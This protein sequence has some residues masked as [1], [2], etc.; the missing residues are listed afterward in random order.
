MTSV[1]QRG[2]YGRYLHLMMLVADFGVLNIA[3]LLTC[4]ISPEF[5]ETRGRTVWLLANLTYIPITYWLNVTHKK[6]AIQMDHVVRNALR[7]VL[8]YALI[9]V[10]SVYF[11]GIDH[12]RWYVFVE[13][14]GL[15]LVIFPIW[16]SLS[17]LIL[18]E[19]RRHGKNFV[20]VVVIGA[21]PTAERLYREMLSD[22]GFGYKI[23]G[24]FDNDKATGDIPADLYM[25]G[26][27]NVAEFVKTQ[28]VDEMYFSIS[29]SDD[30]A[31]SMMIKVA[32]D[33]AIQFYY[34]PQISKYIKRE[35]TLE[36]MGRMP[37]M[38]TRYNPLGLM[39][40]RMAK[41]SFDVIFSSVALIC[42][43][44]IFIPVAIAIKLSSPGPVFFTQKRTG[45]RGREF[46]CYKFRTMRVNSQS[47]SAQA[48]AHD[49]RKTAVGD[50]LRRSSIDELP[51]FINVWL[52][53][54]SVVGPRPHMI[55]HTEQYSKL[56]DK[57][58]VRHVVKPG[59]TGW[60]Q[61]NGF[62]G[63]TD[64]LW[65]M[66]KRVDYDV[67]YIEHWRFM[68]DIKI[69]IRTIMNAVHGEKNAF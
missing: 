26:L 61:V 12:M 34:V 28:G 9:F 46:K 17:R 67:W 35:F 52:G 39:A 69:I 38:S 60:A 10:T 18:K 41:R 44:I 15:N 40:G 29:G 30:M 22:A 33:N 6:R 2:R 37:V 11:V 51:Q 57:Y 19:Y 66:E 64:Q 27:E 20:R 55:K 5:V 59:I 32:D 45:Y 4:L 50:F 43:P 56:I 21:N 24:F 47:D 1:V 42:S 7:G 36:L 54:M 53:D 13:Y 25:G 16:W 23:I 62:R 49:P 3:F 31:I 8:G 68:L 58:M 65:K 63:Q 48:T 14:L